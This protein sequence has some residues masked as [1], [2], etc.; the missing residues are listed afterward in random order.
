MEIQE[1]IKTKAIRVHS[2]VKSGRLSANI[3]LTLNK[4]LIRPVMTYGCP[5]WEFAADTHI[6]DLRES[7]KRLEK[8]LLNTKLQICTSLTMHHWGEEI[9][10]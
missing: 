4:A 3:K 5:T 10:K 9:T 6:L 1:I 2:F 7:K 8:V